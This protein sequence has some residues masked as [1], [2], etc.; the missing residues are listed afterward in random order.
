MARIKLLEKHEVEPMAA[1]LY[2]KAEDGIGRVINLFKVLAHSPKILRDWNRLGTTLLI[3][4]ETSRKLLE[5]AIIRVGEINQAPY[6]LAAHRVI[7]LDCGISQQQIDDLG[8]WQ[9]STYF[10]DLEQAIL[11]YTDEVSRDIRVSD[12]A[13]N[14]LRQHF[15][16]KQMVEITVT[17]GYYH[18]VCRFLE[19]MQV[20]MEKA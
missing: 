14:K 15:S 17:I 7:G 20:D 9:G 12:D 13:F 10:D 8:D 16:E 6:E 4:G 3:K 18:M 1:D 19:P 5:L 11:Q 2:Q